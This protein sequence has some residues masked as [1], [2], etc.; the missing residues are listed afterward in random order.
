MKKHH[1]VFA[2]TFFF[3]LGGNIL[4]L[5]LVFRLTDQ[6]AFSPG[7][8]GAYLALGQLFYFL[9]CNLYRRLG[10]AI[11]PDRVFPAAVLVVFLASV[12]LGFARIQ[13]LA[14]ASYWILQLGAG[15]YWAPVTAWLTG[16]LGGHELSR[17][18]SIFNRT[19]MVGNILGP[20]ISGNL[21]NWNRGLNFSFICVCYFSALF[22][23]YLMKRRD[24]FRLRSI[25]LNRLRLR[26]FSRNPRLDTNESSSSG[27][28][29]GIVSANTARME[30][31]PAAETLDKRFDLYRYR[32]WIG[33][34]SSNMVLG[35]LINIVPL[36]IRD[37]LGFTAG[38][39]GLM[40]FFRCIAGFIGFI[41]LARFATWHFN[42]RWFIVLQIGLMFSILLF[43]PAGN[44][45]FLFYFVAIL[46]GFMNSGC[47]TNSLYY[48]GITGNNPKKNLALHEMIISLG[49]AAGTAGGG[50]FYQH[51]RF[52]GTCLVFFL[53]LGMG[54]GLLVLINRKESSKL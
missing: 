10:S 11:D 39:A 52:T 5:S 6:F 1:F 4:N 28:D 42:R 40:L 2:C 21:Y 7:Q 3:A 53:I 25:G 18:I 24:G 15:F 32:S 44:R 46:Y 38:S 29:A 9:S 34:F 36:H 27:K 23:L 8:T 54:M 26:R 48:A 37:G 43:L 30:N 22:S 12:P 31:S 14:Y 41:L 17:R 13:G 35:V 47:N 33:N 19:W 45:L 16:G 50:F 49:N 20:L 51:I